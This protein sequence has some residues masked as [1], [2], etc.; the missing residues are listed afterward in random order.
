MHTHN[1]AGLNN[2]DGRGGGGHHDQAG[3]TM[4]S[5]P[6]HPARPSVDTSPLFA[7]ASTRR[8]RIEAAVRSARP[9]WAHA[10][11]LGEEVGAFA[12][13]LI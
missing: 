12:D 13:F 3:N 4:V 11:F 7:I 6:L 5:R 1:V 2:T 10:D 9:N 8:L